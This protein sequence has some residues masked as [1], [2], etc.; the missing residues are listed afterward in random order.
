MLAESGS[1]RRG[2]GRT[3]GWNDPGLQVTLQGGEADGGPA[4]RLAVGGRD[5]GQQ[6]SDKGTYR[7]PGQTGSTQRNFSLTALEAG[8]HEP[9]ASGSP[10][11]CWGLSPWFADCSLLCT[12]GRGV[13]CLPPLTG[14][15]VRSGSPPRCPRFNVLASVKGR[16]QTQSR[17]EVLGV[18][19]STG[20]FGGVW[21]PS[22]SLM[23]EGSGCGCQQGPL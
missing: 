7:A 14:T 21:D 13:S 1:L 20:E 9:G 8:I 4:N 19:A 17:P 3:T 16:C 10:G 23:A 6:W 15:P 2:R 18:R 5:G 12:R 11:F 22:P